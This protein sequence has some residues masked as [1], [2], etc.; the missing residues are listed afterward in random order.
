MRRIYSIGDIHGNY[1][2]LMALWQKLIEEGPM[3]LYQDQI[4]FLGDYE[5]RGLDTKKVIQQ[6]IDWQKE[7]N[8]SG[9]QHVVCLKGNHTDMLLDAL[10]PLHPIYGD[11][12]MWLDQGG[13]ETL[14]SYNPKLAKISKKAFR[15]ARE[16]PEL[17]LDKEHVEWLRNLPL[18]LVNEDF[19]FVHGGLPSEPIEVILQKLAQ[20]DSQTIH[21]LLWLRNSFIYSSFDWGRRIIFAHTITDEPTV[22]VNKVGIN[23]LFSKTDKLTAIELPSCR[24][25]YQNRL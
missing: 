13:D 4:I 16:N 25:F 12:E 2:T 14:K 11:S 5:D 3:D 22:Q 18:L 20:N 15:K 10:N 9:E 23:T 19:A 24:F 17:Y 21:D 7:Y 6:L 8:K 1:S